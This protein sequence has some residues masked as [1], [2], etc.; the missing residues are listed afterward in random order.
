MPVSTLWEVANLAL[1]ALGFTGVV[2]FIG[3]RA[4]GE[5]SGGDLRRTTLMITAGLRLL[6]AALLPLVFI[7][8]ELADKTV[9]VVSSAI[10]FLVFSAVAV[11]IA[12]FTREVGI[13]AVWFITQL[14][15]Y[16]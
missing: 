3:R 6:F 8:F 5:W 11:W 9:W 2:A 4:H 7:Y 14:E 15:C 10:C 13:A 1:V 16:C 12:R